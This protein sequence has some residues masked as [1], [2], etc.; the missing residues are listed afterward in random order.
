MSMEARAT[1]SGAV[2]ARLLNITERR[3]QQLAREGIVPKVRHGE[4]PLAGCIRGYITFLQKGNAG[5]GADVTD[6][7]KLEPFKRRA[8]YQGELEK[9]KL[10]TE[11]RELIPRIEVEQ[12][13]AAQLKVTAECFD[14]LPDILERDCGLTPAVLSK[15]EACLD[16]AREELYRRMT[17]EEGDADS[18]A[19]ERA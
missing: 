10:E 4:Y 7:D 12:E 16:R 3:L 15:V 5:E 1:F 6:P 17:E 11:R 13:M 2:I 8:F 18:A 9:L 19:G 14:T